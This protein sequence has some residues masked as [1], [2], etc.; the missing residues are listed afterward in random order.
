MRRI[1]SILIS[2]LCVALTA[3]AQDFAPGQQA[4]GLLESKN[5]TVDYATGI[6]H[7]KIP[8]Y[9]LKSGDYELPISLDYTGKGVKVEDQSGLVG[10]NW[11]LN[12]GGVVTR[13]V[14]GG[15]PD[16]NNL[17][18]Y[19]WTENDATPLEEDIAKV[20]RHERDGESDVFTAVFGGQSVSF[21]IRK[22]SDNQI[23]AE[24]LQRTNVRIECESRSGSQIDGWIVTDAN[25]NRYIYRQKEWTCNLNKQDA[26]SFNGIW[27]KEY[28]SSWYLTC[29]EPVNNDPIHFYYLGGNPSYANSEYSSVVRYNNTYLTNYVYGRP[30]VTHTFDFSKYKSE[31][32]SAISQAMR[33][34]QDQNIRLQVDNQMYIYISQGVWIK[35]PNFDL[36]SKQMRQNTRIMGMAADFKQVESASEELINLLSGLEAMYEKTNWNASFY[37]SQARRAVEKSLED[38]EYI[39][40]RTVSSGSSCKIYSP[41]LSRI[42]CREQ[43]LFY[44]TAEHGKLECVESQTHFQKRISGYRLSYSKNYLSSLASYGKDSLAIGR[45]DFHYYEETGTVGVMSDV[46][47]YK[48]RKSNDA[49]APFDTMLDEEYAKIGSLEEITLADGG[50]IRIDYELNRY[51]PAEYDCYGGIRIKSLL[52][53]NKAENKVDTVTYRYEIGCPP[54]YIFPSNNESKGNSSVTDHITYSRMKFKGNA[55]L[56]PGNNGMYYACVFETVAGKGSQ[57]Y[58]FNLANNYYSN[59]AY[60]Y[61]LCG[62]PVTTV[63]MDNE[64]NLKRILQN[65]YYTDCWLDNSSFPEIPCSN[66]ENFVHLDSASYHKSLPQVLADEDYMDR[67]YLEDFYRNQESVVINS[68]AYYSPYHDFYLVNIAPRIPSK[69][70]SLSYKLFYGGATL[71]K[72]QVEYRFTEGPGSDVQQW[73]QNAVPF[74]R[75]VY[76]YDNLCRN[77]S[78]TRVV[79]YDSKGDSCVTHVL[80]VADMDTASHEAVSKMKEKNIVAPVV[81]QAVVKNGC[82]VEESVSEYHVAETGKG[83]FFGLSKVSSYIPEHPV[84]SFF[85]NEHLL[86]AYGEENYRN[87]KVC[88]FDSIGHT[89]YMPVAVEE[90]GTRNAFYYDCFYKRKLLSAENCASG[91]LLAMDC[92]PFEP[93]KKD[94]EKTNRMVRLVNYARR[95]LEGFTSMNVQDISRNGYHEFRQTEFFEW[96]RRIVELLA[97]KEAW[98][99]RQSFIDEADLLLDSIAVDYYVP[100]DL[101]VGWHGELMFNYYIPMGLPSPWDFDMEEFGEFHELIMDAVANSNDLRDYFHS[102]LPLADKEVEIPSAELALSSDCTHWKLYAL[103]EGKN[104]W[105]QYRIHCGGENV[106]KTIQL[107]D[108]DIH[109]VQVFDIDTSG[110]AGAESVTVTAISGI[111]YIALLPEGTSF[112]AASYT[113]SGKIA[114][115][116]NQ[117]MELEKYEYDSAGRLIRITDRN[118]NTL[119]EKQYNIL[120]H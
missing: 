17:Y 41:V 14:R 42:C 99:G 8:L 53:D 21:I 111:S 1:T 70:N 15:I 45:M 95:F 74:S 30:M 63:T 34:I 12:T 5:V 9:T 27:N 2:L 36:T 78:P 81:K 6:F 73:D 88:G 80:R 52:T 19:I 58:L 44:Y 28:L 29:I 112:E 107:Q 106:D 13:T 54:Y 35:N 3:S 100:L 16:E 98:I 59:M 18:G 82:L 97:R 86:Y 64:G 84:T 61:W 57:A 48:K 51:S 62:L 49:N 55:I 50:R 67:E 93:M 96:G 77:V 103:P 7:Y 38:V 66:Q 90:G 25:G 31:F 72:E 43:L 79:T 24:P 22:N 65:I 69:S 110:Y 40:E 83:C 102:L 37:F 85:G 46:Y 26:V 114:A 23:Y 119:E 33:S 10:Y 105:I 118:G 60:P 39:T 92:I 68:S 71:L 94:V 91:K 76:Y 32:D 20:N 116:F 109:P 47:G 87:R 120:N 89:S 75:T 11:T 113:L 117:D 115:K 101:F 108:S 4:Q 56:C 104:N